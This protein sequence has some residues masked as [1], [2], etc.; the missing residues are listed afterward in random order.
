[1]GDVSWND[2]NYYCQKSGHRMITMT[3]PDEFTRVRHFLSS[4]RK[5]RHIY[6]GALLMDRIASAPTVALYKHVC[7]VWLLR[8]AVFVTF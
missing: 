6:V 4:V 5:L 2:A 7:I 8:I 3:T 1:M